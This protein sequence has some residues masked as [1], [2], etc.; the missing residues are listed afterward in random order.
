[1]YPPRH[2]VERP[3]PPMNPSDDDLRRF[4][5]AII[6]QSIEDWIDLIRSKHKRTDN[7]GRAPGASFTDI[8]LFFSEGLGVDICDILLDLDSETV[9]NVLEKHLKNYEQYGVVPDAL[10]PHDYIKLQYN[11][12]KERKRHYGIR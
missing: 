5:A 10:P 7:R 3:F 1:M 8:R 2:N 12:K 9:L 11:T 6:Y 4:A